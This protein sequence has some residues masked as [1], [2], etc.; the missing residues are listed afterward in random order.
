MKDS[1]KT[2]KQLIEELSILRKRLTEEGRP[3]KDITGRKETDE[4]HN[5]QEERFRS[6]LEN[7]PAIIFLKDLDS[8][9]LFI[10]RLWEKVFQVSKEDVVGKFDHEVFSKEMAQAVRAND[11]IVIEANA[12]MEFE[13]TVP[14]DDGLHTYISIK[15]PLYD[16]SGKIE[17]IC[18]IATDITDRKL[19][20]EA[21]R[22]SEEKYSSLFTNMLN[23]FA[24]HKIVVDKDNR[25]VDYI[26]LEV[27]DAF[28]KL[29]GLKREDLI[30]RGVKEVIP[31]I[32]K[33]EFDWIGE[34]G[35]I[36][37]EGGEL[38]FEQYFEPLDK[39]YSILG[40]SNKKGYFAAVFED[41]T[42]QKEA[43]IALQQSEEKH[44]TLFET[45]EQGVVYQDSTGKI[46]SANNAAEK[47][48]G[49]TLSQMQGLTSMDPRW[50][51]IHEDGSDFPGETH[52][53]MVALRTGE[54]VIGVVMGVFEDS[55][56]EYRWLTI[57]AIPL[58]RPNE[59]KPNKV[60]TTF[61]DITERKWAEE[62]IKKSLAE[63]E[64]LLKEIHHRVKNNLQ[65]VSSILNLQSGYIKNKELKGIFKES[66]DRIK[67]MALVH[68]QL[69]QSKDFSNIGLP[70][71]FK[72]L[73][74][75]IFNS[76]VDSPSKVELKMEIEDIKLD[77]DTSMVLGLIVNELC[78]NA[79]KYA[80][81]E[82]RQGELCVEFRRT[83]NENYLLVIRDNGVG[84][85]GDFDIDKAESMGFLLVESMVEQL[86]G[87]LEI[88]QNSGTS[89]KII[90][91]R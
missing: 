59:K 71:Y 12:P 6:I 66:Q 25:P 41:I 15:F 20:S 53:S 49:L 39:W 65:V 46:T 84:L 79:L 31:D 45:M 54:P 47:I 68:A 44:R 63:K 64:V 27:N 37:L 17:A 1:L 52:P 75:N 69:Y 81:P 43:A 51:S 19:A 7:S 11:L 60:Y 33:S 21:L 89:F 50:K 40:Y 26:F 48:L 74:E 16:A 62:L 13:E 3:V 8:R 70:E 61:F 82:G 30:G 90:F 42:K 22:E 91:P 24:Y 88:D 14:H 34:Y 18:G 78:S 9:Y 38:R 87:T 32:E 35:K 29:T 10:N 23:G 56:E 4:A 77:I 85:L 2:K 57:D 55:I 72:I 67:S 28:E 83:D 36:A 80:F 58:F 86:D 73:I 76:Y 5:V